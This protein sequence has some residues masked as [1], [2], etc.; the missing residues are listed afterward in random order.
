[1]PG[2]A[3]GQ[4]ETPEL[5]P[6]VVHVVGPGDTLTRLADTYQT[7]VDAIQV[8]NGLTGLSQLA[9]GEALI[10]PAGQQSIPGPPARLY[11]VQLGDDLHRVSTLFDVP[12]EMLGAVNRIVNPYEL[13]SGQ[14][15]AV[16]LLE[17]DQ[18]FSGERLAQ[19]ESL[20][21][22]ALRSDI[23]PSSLV[24]ANS[25][26]NPF[27]VTP[28]HALRLPRAEAGGAAALAWPWFDMSLNQSPLIQGRTVLVEVITQ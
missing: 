9:T 11:S 23:P 25:G 22:K 19:S 12:V 13:H 2:T 16:P 21:H 17:N 14:V 15:I 18:P 3:I 5:P 1:M 4:E 8:A 10:I 27:A 20:W 6:I 24:L 28:Y 7:T 26:L